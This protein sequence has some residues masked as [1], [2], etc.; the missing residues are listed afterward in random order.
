MS[1]YMVAR[2]ELT[3]YLSMTDDKTWLFLHCVTL[4]DGMTLVYFYFA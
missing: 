2:R 1:F 3:Y 4:C